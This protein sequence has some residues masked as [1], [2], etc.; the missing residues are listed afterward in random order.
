MATF[1]MNM[2]DGD[3]G[4]AFDSV[5]GMNSKGEPVMYVGGN[6]VA[7]VNTGKMHFVNFW[8]QDSDD[9]KDSEDF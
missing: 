3:I 6:M 7:E 2:D 8:P 4:F 5:S 9:D 1:F